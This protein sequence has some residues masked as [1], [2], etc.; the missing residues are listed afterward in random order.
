MLAALTL[1]LI[2]QLAGEVL[3]HSFALP[4]PGPVIGMALLFVALMLRGGPGENLRQTSGQLLQHLSLLF[5][6]AGTGIVLYGERIAAEWLPLVVAMVASTLL[7]IIVTA[8]LLQALARRRR[9]REGA[10]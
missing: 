8:L 4:V 5:V 10:R 7:A 6:P 2:F 3:A 9:D 1:L